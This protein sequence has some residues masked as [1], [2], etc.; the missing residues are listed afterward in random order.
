MHLRAFRTFT[1][2]HPTQDSAGPPA[3]S[4]CGS[5]HEAH[6]VISK[7]FRFARTKHDPQGIEMLLQNWTTRLIRSLRTTAKKRRSR[8]VSPT[9]AARSGLSFPRDVQRLEDKTLLTITT[10]FNAGTGVL[11][12]TSDG[13]DDTLPIQASATPG[14]IT[15]DDGGG[16]GSST[17]TG[18]NSIIFNGNGG[19]DKLVIS[20]ESGDIFR[21][22]VGTTFTITFDGGTE[23]ANDTIV[24]GGGNATFTETYTPT[25]GSTDAGNLTFIDGANTLSVDFDDL[26]SLEDAA[27]AGT[28]TAN[29]NGAAD[30]INVVD[31][32][33]LTPVSTFVQ[34]PI[35]VDGGDRDD[36]GSFSAGA[37]QDGWKFMEQLLNYTL[38]ESFIP[39]ATK[40][41]LVIGANGG[42][43]LAAIN[44]V[45][46]A[47]GLNLA[48]VDF[49]TT[50]FDIQN[51]DFTQYKAFFV[52]S[53]SGN[54]SGGITSAQVT[55][56]ATRT[57][58]ITS[59]VRSGGGIVAL[60]EE[61][62][63][64]A[65]AWLAIPDPFV[66]AD[67]F[68][69]IQR[70][71][72]FLATAF[73][74][75][76]LGITNTE[77]SNGTPTHN[78]FIGPAGFNGLDPW[79]VFP[80]ADN[81][82]DAGNGGEFSPD[83]Q[84]PA[85]TVVNGTGGDEINVLGQGAINDDVGGGQSLQINDGVTT[86]F[87]TI[88]AAHKG[89][90][91]VNAGGGGDTV[92]VN[93][94]TAA[95]AVDLTALTI[96]GEAGNDSVT[97]RAIPD[98]VAA[99]IDG[100][101]NTDSIQ[102]RSTTNTLDD[103]E[104]TVSI[105][106]GSGTDSI[107]IDDSGSATGETVSFTTAVVEGLTGVAGND[108]TLAGNEEN[109]T[110]STSGGVDTLSVNFA[111]VTT[112]DLTNI[113]L[114]ASGG[115]DAVNIQTDTPSDA[116]TNLNGNAGIDTFTYAAGAFVVT[117]SID[118]GSQED[119]LV[120]SNYTTARVIQLDGFGSTDGFQ[121][122]DVS[123]ASSLTAGFDNIDEILGTTASD[124]LIGP[125]LDNHWDIGLRTATGAAADE[126]VLVSGRASANPNTGNATTAGRP[127]GTVP[128]FAGA[129]ERDLLWTTFE[130][131]TGGSQ[132]DHF[133]LRDQS[134][135]TG[136]VSGGLG[137]DSIDYRDWP[138]TVINVDLNTNTA[139]AIGALGAGVGGDVDSSIENAFGGDAN[140]TIYGDDD[141]N[142]LGD[143]FGADELIGDRAREGVDP[144]GV[145]S[146]NDTFRLEPQDG[147]TDVVYDIAGND[148]VDFRFAS[149]GV[150]YDADL[151][152]IQD[153]FNAGNNANVDLRLHDTLVA[154]I[155]P[156]PVTG[157]T[158]Y[159]NVIGSQYNDIF[160][161]DPLSISGNFPTDIPVIRNVDG[162]DPPND[163]NPPDPA[164]ANPPGDTLKFNARGEDA[165][166][167]G[168]SIT[169]DGVGTV[170]YRSIETLTTF[171]QDS[172]IIDNLDDAFRIDPSTTQSDNTPVRWN[173]DSNSGF[174]GSHL[175]S[176]SDAFDIGN[177]HSAFWTFNGLSDGLYR[178]SATWPDNLDEP[179]HA[180]DAPFTIRDGGN[181]LAVIPVNQRLEPDDFVEDGTSWEDLGTFSVQ[182]HTLEVILTNEAN[183]SVFADA[184][185]VERISSGP[186]LQV[187]EL[188]TS[189]V[190]IDA[191]SSV[192]FDTT[193]GDP[194]TRTFVI[195]NDGDSNLTLSSEVELIQPGTNFTLTQ[196][197]QTTI[198][199]GESTAFTVT[200]DATTANEQGDFP[201]EIRI[202]S[203]DVDEN[204]LQLP[205]Q[206][207][208]PTPDTDP[209]NDVNPFTFSLDGVVNNTT[210]VDDGDLDFTLIGVWSGPDGD[211]FQG[212]DRFTP[213]DNDGSRAIWRFD[214]LPDGRY[215][216]STTFTEE[217]E[218]GAS[219]DAMFT[220]SD[221]TGVIT[222]ASIDQTVAP[223]D[224]SDSGVSW[225]DL[226]GPFTITGGS[227]IVELL[228]TGDGSETVI[229]DAVRIERL[230]DQ[231]Q[232][233]TVTAS[234]DGGA[235]V[236]IADDSG[237]LD[238][239]TLLPGSQSIAE[240]TVANDGMAPLVISEPVSHSGQFVLLQFDGQ[241]PTGALTQ[242][243]AMGASTTFR[244]QLNAS[245]AGIINDP[246]AFVT[247]D[248][249][250][251]PFNLTLRA[252]VAD[253]LIVDNLDAVG[254]TQTG[255]TLFIKKDGYNDGVHFSAGDNTGDAATWT[256]TVD[257]GRTYR[258][259]ATWTSHTDRATD[260]PYTITGIN[261]GP[262]TVTRNQQVAPDDRLVN[263]SQFED[264][265]VFQAAGATIT[266]SLGDNADGIVL[267]DAIRV[268]SLFGP[269]I[270]L[271]ESGVNLQTGISTVNF[272]SA[273]EAPGNITRTFTIRNDGERASA[274]GNLSLPAGFSLVGAFPTDIAAGGTQTFQVALDTTTGGT[275]GGELSFAT[276]D[277]DETPFRVTVQGIVFGTG[278][279]IDNADGAPGYTSTGFAQFSGTGLNGTFET[280]IGGGGANSA[281]WSFTS[282]APGP[283]NVAATWTADPNRATD[284]PYTV[285]DSTG[286]ELVLINQETSP[287]DFT[288]AGTAWELLGNVF[289][290]DATGTLTVTLTDDAIEYVDA[291]AIR[292]E[293]LTNVP[294]IQ[295][296]DQAT[297][298][299]VADG[300][301]FPIAA[302][303]G[304]PVTTTFEVLN[305][306][307]GPLILGPVFLPAGYTTT[308]AEQT[309]GA[310][311]NTTFDVTYQATQ[312]GIQTGDFSFV[313]NDQDEN[314]FN[315]TL[316]GAAG[317]PTVIIDNGDTGFAQTGFTAFTGQGYFADVHAKVADNGGDTATWTF[318]A[319]TAGATY[320]VSATWSPFFNRATDAPYS[321]S[322][323]VGGTITRDVDQR[324]SPGDFFDQGVAWDD[325]DVVRV[326]G[327][328]L[329]VTLGDN[330]DGTVIADAIRVE[331]VTDLAPEISVQDSGVLLVDGASAIDFGTVDVGSVASRT[332][333]VTNTGSA[334]L[335][336]NNVISVPGGFTVSTPFGSTTVA[337]G[338]MTT[339]AI[340]MTTT[341][342]GNFSGTVTFDNDDANESPFEFDVGGTVQSPSP[343]I[344]D[345]GEG[346]FA[347]SGFTPFSGQGFKNDVHFTSGD[348]TGDSASWTFNGLT[349]GSR[350]LVSASW[351]PFG[352]RATD[353]PF[354]VSG[355][356]GG[357]VTIDFNQQVGPDDRQDSGFS[358]EDIGVFELAGTTLTVSVTD[359]ANNI[360]I[361]DA[362]RIEPVSGPEI[363]VLDGTVSIA[364]GSGTVDFG[365][366]AQNATVTKM[367]TVRN[368]GVTDLVL[369]P[370]SLPTGFSLVGANFTAGQ[371]VGSGSFTS[372]EVQIDSSTLTP[373]SGIIQFGNNDADE[374][375]FSFNLTGVIISNS[376]QVIDDGDAGF[377]SS[378]FT[379]FTGQGFGNDVQFSAGDNTG[380]AAT[381]T[382]NG[383]TAGG[384]Y[385]ISTSWTPFANRA[386]DAPYT[387]SG[388]MGGPFT[389]D[390]NQ[391]VSP[392][393]RQEQGFSF[394]DLG[395][396]SPTGTTLTVSLGD[397]ADNF[398]IADAVRLEQIVGPEIT[399]LDG[400]TTL[401]DGSST[402][403][404]GTVTPGSTITKTFTVTNTGA[405]N[406]IVQPV[407]VPAG[408]TVI[409]NLTA[410]QTIL[411]T[412]S[413]TF[414]IGIDPAATGAISGTLQ[415]NNTDIDED[416]FDFTVEANVVGS[417]I[418]D[419]GDVGYSS[420]GF[421]S[422]G[423]Q[424]F[425]NDVQF[426]A[427]DNSGDSATW[428]FSDLVAGGRYL[429]S[430]T[431][432]PFNNRA[433]DAPFT[434]SGV[435]GGPVTADVNQLVSPVSRVDQGVP[436]DDLG[437]FETTGSTLT[438]SLSD[439]ANGV[440]IADAI[441]IERI[442]GPEVV[443]LDGTTSLVDGVSTVD[444]GT[445]LVSGTLTKTF[446][447][448][449]VGAT[450]L[451]VQPVT[452][453]TGF[454]IVSNLG[455]GQTIAPDA[456]A[457]FEIGV[458]TTAADSFSGTLQFTSDDADESPFEIDIEAVVS[459][460]LILDDG[461]VGYTDTA[462]YTLFGNQ[463]FSL[464]VREALVDAT[465]DTA[466]WTFTNVPS[467]TYRVSA[468][469][470]P[471]FNR[472]TDAPYSVAGGA[473]VDIN[474]QLPPSDT[475]FVTVQ[476]P[477]TGVFF[478]D[479]DGGFAHGGGNLV[480]TLTDDA[481]QNVIAD[482]IRIERL[483]P[484]LVEGGDLAGNSDAA[485][486]TDGQAAIVVDQAVDIWSSTGLTQAQVVAL[487]TVSVTVT[488]LAD[489]HL[490]A[491]GTGSIYLDINGA[492][493]GWFIDATPATDSEL[494]GVDGT[495]IGEVDLLT[496]VLHELGHILG[497]GDLDAASNP[498]DLMS[499][500][501]PPGTRRL[502]NGTG[503][504]LSAVSSTPVA[505]NDAGDLG[506]A[507]N[508]L[509]TEQ[510]PSQVITASEGSHANTPSSP[511]VAVQ[512][513][514]DEAEETIDAAFG[515][516]SLSVDTDV[517]NTL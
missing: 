476:D 371:T 141:N 190:V 335:N 193:I 107:T 234:I 41:L 286:S 471:Y 458:N 278:L 503:F 59:F 460:A 196:P 394:E 188:A 168:L 237:V 179:A 19:D 208:N 198:A 213:A 418:L 372:F 355:I 233:V 110:V 114:N 70:Q 216:V 157:N 239:G 178:V 173:D 294:E 422:F 464:D 14:E 251:S 512:S 295:V 414:E 426:A 424:G 75:A 273:P 358:F 469:W 8:K 103:I 221:V 94:T 1:R 511:L 152:G 136:T 362:V 419:N 387:I 399:V 56:L 332:F 119:T 359:D 246:L 24:L 76:G 428:T 116:T 470:T 30:V 11:T 304:T 508:E 203:N 488:D 243:L 241:D 340:D 175:F 402:V 317:A 185:R 154:G 370:I 308:Y 323:I 184:V 4:G 459:A 137:S 479:L 427:G 492:G 60:T 285:T 270:E 66:I 140:D 291:D 509:V 320:R 373:K 156:Q 415:F 50:S 360:V 21:P 411:S 220:V 356:V 480:V 227:I 171:D 383:L 368:D 391:L 109:L 46:G 101:G 408:F 344:I 125:N 303:P 134:S 262:V 326:T 85:G 147:V 10:M 502:P 284:A 375:P 32:P 151:T 271:E 144:T 378:G 115:N 155:I 170:T 143:G 29:I 481:N 169:A 255:Y 96:N 484:L 225:E 129:G 330:A 121:G 397:D 316:T 364:E 327:N 416:P 176:Q 329:T 369:Q 180:T 417:Q 504:A 28:F 478:A 131:L 88:N 244:L 401:V 264:L 305:P 68:Q 440:V 80:G 450:P 448:T 472:A 392:D 247:D 45:V 412:M 347:S 183:G 47:G 447:V 345:N 493:H 443:V 17:E 321:V 445:V 201:A 181:T 410:G 489:G 374:G 160:D 95:R 37:N 312:T 52:P 382:F 166:D 48:N 205:G 277:L 395:V 194:L 466:T 441:R 386:A 272:G 279:I 122:R 384:R 58:D 505:S 79:V 44:S 435:T 146:G 223:D 71:T 53:D 142:I 334:T 400:V 429:V 423:G 132:A 494:I 238:F 27:D 506:P 467:G 172:R 206:G 51:V 349:M 516:L 496:V 495:P 39:T 292:I 346:T 315:F 275:F 182:S 365:N 266:V 451:T 352:N 336:L 62:V 202:F 296:R 282:L 322:G 498:Q 257:Q 389:V 436:F 18:V 258:I 487:Q 5:V 102:I 456:S 92:T 491:A 98:A 64:N 405:T 199:P 298:N 82:V 159:E 497:Y 2:P 313:T 341:T 381:W 167:T 195:Q 209:L 222:T 507:S 219:D 130:N 126:G 425:Q 191:V 366:V 268:E 306:G 409:N 337:P 437:V 106:G 252:T 404:F 501:L 235:S 90:V 211:G 403:D 421:T 256:F 81:L 128:I 13:A 93:H 457:T 33:L 263:A 300:S 420:S 449:N 165:I 431:W 124:T 474:Q 485:L 145:T 353:A 339:F 55:D 343:T 351:T 500:V 380:D 177:V 455:A 111:G 112:T 438:V 338:A 357:P 22:A 212:D 265:G 226:G 499:D 97:V 483:G 186:E 348:N 446:T 89:S 204:V 133:D 61:G 307:S 407:T 434:V 148:T 57:A 342:V 413:A 254:F 331:Q 91:T 174:A 439:D 301:T 490:A 135:I 149:Q 42:N 432:S 377:A 354:T 228:D 299:N 113:T 67:S 215:R 12:F 78:R 281:S 74:N 259:G 293:F 482:A 54:T 453:P 43:A 475:S 385:L 38:T 224:F 123:T 197:D 15:Y 26:E 517:L 69:T 253:S 231:V 311:G 248:P 324:V 361:A 153:V 433:T 462:G 86:S 473:A 49:I 77:L 406:L 232:D 468:T 187:F 454:T 477:A 7:D 314:P 513:R 163:G 283:Y 158:P 139:N 120:Y 463:G 442:V 87:L 161:I 63:A 245:T 118:G 290:V 164:T 162:N 249:D 267:A 40:D 325:L 310:G 6:H 9:T 229:A 236:A 465:N 240:F 117:G 20:M 242:T 461:D 379:T 100:G 36:H 214:D 138:T 218:N 35:V 104:G 207:V 288:E 99:T 367:F 210:I 398:V 302:V 108:F 363:D 230:Y 289:I 280:G 250:E 486:L 396:F 73:A 31:G 84:D 200:L 333:T 287:N 34:G 452:V 65:Y 269:E 189:E 72:T 318:N 25:P 430:T 393:D 23:T 192:D 16:L 217:P 297:T 388:V 309:I 105:D 376:L 514:S 515:L 510:E 127:T 260:A 3:E 276:D 83:P 150:V 390:V 319:L 350:Y 328:S 274:L 261:G 444:F